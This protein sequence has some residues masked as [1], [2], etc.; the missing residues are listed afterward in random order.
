[1]KFNHGGREYTVVGSVTLGVYEEGELYPW[2][3]FMLESE[4]GDEFTLEFD[5]GQWIAMR[6][7]KPNQR[8]EPEHM[9]ALRAGQFL[10]IDGIKMRIKV[11]AMAHLQTVEGVMDLAFPGETQ[12]EYIDGTT[13][14]E[15]FS[16]EWTRERVNWVRGKR[17]SHAEVAQGFGKNAFSAPNMGYSGPT[18]SYYPQAYGNAPKQKDLLGLGLLALGLAFLAMLVG[19][20]TTS[21]GTVVSEGQVKV[22]QQGVQ[23]VSFGPI[24]VQKSGGTHKLSAFVEAVPASTTSSR[25]SPSSFTVPTTA[26]TTQLPAASMSGAEMYTEEPASQNSMSAAP[27]NYAPPGRSGLYAESKGFS[28][29]ESGQRRVVVRGTNWGAGTSVGYQLRSGLRGAGWLWIFVVMSG[30]MGVVLVILA[31]GQVRLG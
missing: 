30:G 16:A 10:T 2:T 3:E 5:D 29:A 14:T 12:W 23:Q 4:D 7:W 26:P 19:C 28:V 1:M 13:A 20:A 24:D 31:L 25:P 8:M 9:R 27:A 15:L 18:P 21:K 6:D 22:S 11:K 17:L